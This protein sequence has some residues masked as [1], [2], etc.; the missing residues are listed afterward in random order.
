M[1]T[2]RATHFRS[3]RLANNAGIDFPLC[4]ANAARLDMEKGRLP[5]T[6][7][8][9]KVTCGRCRRHPGFNAPA[10]TLKEQP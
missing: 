6:T 10:I 2:R 8:R 9:T 4:Y 7:D 1:S 3:L 5:L